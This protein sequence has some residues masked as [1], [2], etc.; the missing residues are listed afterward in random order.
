[1]HF[2]NVAVVCLLLTVVGI[3][4]SVSAFVNPSASR[5][6]HASQQ[7]MLGHFAAVLGKV[8]P[9]CYPA[10]LVLLGIETWLHW[11]AP[12]FAALLAGSVM[13]FLASIASI[14]F[15][16]PLN[17]RVIQ[18]VAGWQNDH[19]RWDRLHRV[20]VATLAVAG[21]LTTCALVR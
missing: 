2:F 13:W 5:L 17:N 19:R 12:G 18:G 20:R 10:V 1:M 6:D 14:L 7:I 21:I 4:F 16:V 8:M 15:L 3:E 11:H 9:V